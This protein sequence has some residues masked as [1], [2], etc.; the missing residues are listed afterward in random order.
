MVVSAAAIA[1]DESL[2]RNRRGGERKRGEQHC[3]RPLQRRARVDAGRRIEC[4]DRESRSS[5]VRPRGCDGDCNDEPRPPHEV[6]AKLNPR[7]RRDARLHEIASFSTGV[8]RA[9]ADAWAGVTDAEQRA[10]LEQVAQAAIQQRQCD[11]D[12]I[13]RATERDRGRKHGEH[14]LRPVVNDEVKDSLDVR[15]CRRPRR[16]QRAARARGRASSRDRQCAG[17]RRVSRDAMRMARSNARSLTTRSR[18]SACESA[19]RP[20]ERLVEHD[21]APVGEDRLGEPDAG[22]RIGRERLQAC[23]PFV[24]RA[25]AREAR[26]RCARACRQRERRIASRAG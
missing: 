19:P 23:T 18:I 16:T 6:I 2:N 20:V 1:G 11:P 26:N 8:A 17:A 14:V 10:S 3:E 13:R 25:Q 12:R 9:S 7:I 22:A 5:G 24:A 4:V 15:R 21:D